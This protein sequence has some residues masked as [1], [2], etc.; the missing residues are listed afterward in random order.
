[1]PNLQMDASRQDADANT[2]AALAFEGL[3]TAFPLI[4]RTA[5]ISF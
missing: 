1:M 3:S 2:L 4:L 5:Y